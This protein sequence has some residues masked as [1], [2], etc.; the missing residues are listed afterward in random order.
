MPRSAPLVLPPPYIFPR[1]TGSFFLL[2]ANPERLMEALPPDLKLFPGLGGKILF[3]VLRHEDVHAQCDPS[4][5]QYGYSEV[6]LAA[7]VREKALNP[8]GR[9]GLYP[10]CLYVDDDT[11]MAA[12]REV[13]GFPKKMARIEL[14]AHEVSLVRCGLAPEAVPGPV[15]PIK[16]MSAHWSAG[17]QAQPSPFE[18][19]SGSAPHAAKPRFVLPLLGD[20]A[21]LMVFYNTRYMTQPGTGNCTGSDLSQLTK[22]ALADAEVRRV[23]ALHHLRLRV[24]ASI[25][26][27]VYL[28]MQ[29]DREADEICAGWGV[30]V[31]LAFSMGAARSVEAVQGTRDTHVLGQ[32]LGDSRELG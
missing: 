5:A 30:R 24:D 32:I 23:S 16:V 2:D 13:Y 27:P 10:I 19:P 9:M 4:G 26:D 1:S 12:G 3:G 14:G 21:R 17:P 29:A 11:A 8:I 18:V 15:Q 20:L 22:V 31:E 25:N 7:F 28:L 6:L